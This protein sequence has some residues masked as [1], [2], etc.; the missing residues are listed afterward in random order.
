MRFF[1]VRYLR[2]FGL[3]GVFV[4]IGL[5]SASN[6]NAQRV[7]FG[8]GFGGPVY[9]GPAP[10]CGYGYYDYYP[11]ACAPCG[12]YGPRWFE[13]GAFIRADP[14]FGFQRVLVFQYRDR[15]VD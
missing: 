10:F 3:L 4:G 14:W 5:F 12:Y 9:Y 11:Y 15:I 13:G 2:L 7:A 8:V 1:K 6:A